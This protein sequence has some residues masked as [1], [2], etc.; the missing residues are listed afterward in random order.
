MI[1]KKRQFLTATLV[2][3]LG[4]AVAVNWYYT[5]NGEINNN[6]DN[7][8]S[9]QSDDS[10]LGDSVLV[11]GTTST[12]GEETTDVNNI[13][14]EAFFAEAKLTREKANDKITDT[15]NDILSSGSLDQED[16]DKINKLIS[17]YKDTVKTQADT[18]TL[19]KAKTGSEC[20]V[21]INEDNCQVI[22]QKN[23]LNNTVILQITEIIEKNTNISAENLTIIESK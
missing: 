10:N 3:A 11:A 19:I 16:K 15:V 12:D 1:I 6:F 7:Y 14:A 21:I 17:E 22:M 9:T 5:D 18:E 4:A 2:I 8:S 20:V 13:S 23:T